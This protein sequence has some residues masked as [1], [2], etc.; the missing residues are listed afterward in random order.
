MKKLFILLAICC[1]ALQ[2]CAFD[3]AKNG[4]ASC[5]I[6]VPA[7]PAEFDSRAAAELADYL[8]K[9]TGGTFE[10]V[11]ENGKISKPAIF[12]GNTALAAK[13]GIVQSKLGYEEWIIR[14]SGKNIICTGNGQIGSYYAVRRLLEQIGVHSIALDEEV[15]PSQ[16]TLA[17]NIVNEQKKP[18]IAGRNIYDGIPNVLL[19]ARTNKKQWDRYWTWRLRNYANGGH[20]FPDVKRADGY[21]SPDAFYKGYLFNLSPYMYNWHSMCEYISADYY[22]THPEY[23]AMNAK[24]VRA[25]PVK[26][27]KTYYVQTGLCYS[28]KDVHRITVDKLREFIK[29]DRARLPKSQWPELYDISALDNFPTVCLCKDCKKIVAECGSDSD[30]LFYYIN[31]VANAITKEYPEIKIRTYA[32]Y[33]GAYQVPKKILPAK[34]V[35]LQYTDSLSTCDVYKPLK[36]PVN[37]KDYKRFCDWAKVGKL[38]IWDYGIIGG[39]YST[40]IRLEVHVDSFIEDIKLF[41]E[42][43]VQSIFMENELDR[44]APFV[45]FF[46]QQYLY[47]KILIDPYCDVDKYIDLFINNY[48]GSAAPLM[49]DFFNTI[50]EGVRSY[51]GPQLCNRVGDWNHIK[52]DVLVGYYVKLKKAL[53]DNAGTK[54]ELR[55]K[56]DMLSLINIILLKKSAFAKEIAAN[57]VDTKVMLKEFKDWTKECF[58]FF[59]P[60]RWQTYNS[61]FEKRYLPVALELNAP[62]EFK[63]IPESDI[64]IVSY[65]HFRNIPHINSHIVNDPDAINGKAVKSANKDPKSHGEK[66]IIQATATIR[67][68]ATRF[69]MGDVVLDIKKVPQDEKYHLYTFP[70]EVVL[71]SRHYF[72]GHCWGIQA[73][74]SHLYAVGDGT[75]SINRWNVHFRAKFTGPLWVKGSKQE[76]AVWVDSVIFTRPSAAGKIAARNV[77]PGF[78]G[79]TVGDIKVVT[80]FRAPPKTESALVD[81]PDSFNGKAIM[82]AKKDVKFHGVK[83]VVNRI[84]STRFCV[85]DYRFDIKQIPQDEKYHLYKYPTNVTLNQRAYFWGHHWSIQALLG[86]VYK[87]NGTKEENTHEVYFRAKFTGPQWVKGSTKK[88]AIFVDSLIF[89]RPG[90]LAQKKIQQKIQ[91]SPVYALLKDIPADKIKVVTSFTAPKIT[92]SAIVNDPD[93]F[94][95]KAVVSTRSNPAHHGVKATIDRTPATRFCIGRNLMNIS[96]I[97]QDEKYHLYKFPKP[98]TIK[99]RNYFWGYV[100]ALQAQLGSIYK[101]GGSDADNTY[102]VYFSVKFTGPQWVSGSTQKNAVYLDAVFFVKK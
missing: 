56:R 50:R 23:F 49:K 91:S 38:A 76:N 43:G 60:V 21:V 88:N 97:P 14:N 15:V 53:A 65:P 84:P 41:R 98:V 71:Q 69:S 46:L 87:K 101:K 68:P 8:K 2:L 62:A 94:T 75:D 44:S 70:R 9:I 27:D 4:S 102:D 19:N 1:S 82:A 83:S 17:V 47:S 29:R 81:D 80:E 20:G 36:H 64:R 7:N 16:K 58:E 54:Y 22:K 79:L 73:V 40:P 61:D 90:V 93:S 52:G 99:D 31:S 72:W 92:E 26:R 18:A 57:N 74:T 32:A 30:L 96:Q 24:G 35:I 13:N 45:F 85:G 34:N 66:T 3:F 33:S 78:E 11:K 12:I 6:V 95:G 89:V 37:S 55:I 67:V 86:N 63:N 28:N 25:K 59:E 39:I 10:I 5:Q 42:K 77:P 51:K 48:Y 100:W